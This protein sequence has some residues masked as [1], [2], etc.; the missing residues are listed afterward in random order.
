MSPGP[1]GHAGIALV[2]ESE[3]SET[4]QKSATSSSFDLSENRF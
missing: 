4:G 2:E 1:R 3:Y